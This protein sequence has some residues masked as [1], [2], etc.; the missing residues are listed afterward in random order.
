[1]MV[2]PTVL[3]AIKLICLIHCPT[4]VDDSGIIVN[5]V[6]LN[7]GITQHQKDDFLVYLKS[8]L[9]ERFSQPIRTKEGLTL[10]ESAEIDCLRS[11]FRNI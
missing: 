6:N 4:A 1:M 5:A 3:S 2:T 11:M 10:I 7:T 9:S 8:I